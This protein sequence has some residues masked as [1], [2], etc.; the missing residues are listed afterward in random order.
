[1][2]RSPQPMETN[3]MKRLVKSPKVYV[4]DS[5]LPLA[6]LDVRTLHQL[7][8][9]PVADALWEGVV[10]EQLISAKPSTVHANFYRAARGAEVSWASSRCRHSVSE[11]PNLHLAE[12]DCSASPLQGNGPTRELGVVDVN[13]LRSV[14][15]KGQS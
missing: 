8:G 6:L 11:R 13:G 15:N 9:H 14:Q 1:M 3:V 4:R 12:L 7:T 5:G 10:I 2:L